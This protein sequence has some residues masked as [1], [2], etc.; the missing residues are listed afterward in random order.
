MN[1]HDLLKRRSTTILDVRNESEFRTGNV[2][3]SINIPLIELKNNISELLKKQPLVICCESGIRSRLAFDLLKSE[4][5]NE[6]YDGGGWR[7]L[8]I[9]K[10]YK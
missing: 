4:G 5:L 2:E 8:A 3:G 10:M 6:I 7:L 1:L 9:Q